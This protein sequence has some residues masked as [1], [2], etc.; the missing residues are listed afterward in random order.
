MRL[1][2]TIVSR[3]YA[4]P[5][6]TLALVQSAG[7]AYTWDVTFSLAITPS[8]PV[9][10]PHKLKLDWEGFATAKATTLSKCSTGLSFQRTVLLT[11]LVNTLAI[12]CEMFSGFVDAGFV[13]ALPFH[14]GDLE[15]DCVGV[16]TRS[17]HLCKDSKW[18]KMAVFI[19]SST[20]P[21][22][23]EGAYARDKNT[24]ARL[25]AKN[26]G[27]LMREGGRIC[28]TLRYYILMWFYSNLV[29][30][31]MTMQFLHS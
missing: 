20:S 19:L 27:G 29:T 26:A 22:V 30:P 24:S 8:L 4:P 3:K 6:A 17:R 14:H 23:P 25:C 16:S 2:Y 15:P 13:L 31:F 12:D 11:P 7:G 10:R 21:T 5:F 9:P 28:G 1:P 18:L